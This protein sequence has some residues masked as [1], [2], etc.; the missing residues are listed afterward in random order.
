MSNKRIKELK[1][2]TKDE[3]VQKIREVEKGLFEDRMKKSTGQLADVAKL[4]RSRKD[5]ARLKTL[6][7]Q[8]QAQK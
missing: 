8:S 5:L 6:Q 7:V 2:L 1:N 4:W 3:M